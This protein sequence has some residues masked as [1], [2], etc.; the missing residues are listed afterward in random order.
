VDLD[1]PPEEE[2]QCEVEEM[3][4]T[5]VEYLSSGDPFSLP[6]DDP[7]PSMKKLR[8]KFTCSR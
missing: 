6:N 8:Q 4:H 3:I 5:V 7:K 2:E 1:Q